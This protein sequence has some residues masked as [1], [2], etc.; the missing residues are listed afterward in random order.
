MGTHPN[1][2]LTRKTVRHAPRTIR[3]LVD[4]MNDATGLIT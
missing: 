4:E 1:P 3:A 2:T